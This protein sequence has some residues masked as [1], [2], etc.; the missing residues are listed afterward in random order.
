MSSRTI[1]GFGDWNAIERSYGMHP[2]GGEVLTKQDKKDSADINKIMARWLD[3]GVTVGM[4]PGDARYGDFSGTLD[5]HAAQNRIKDAE[6]EFMLQPAHIREACQHDLGVFLEKI[7]T[8][9]GQKELEALGL[10]EELVPPSAAVPPA[11]QAGSEAEAAPA[12][13][14]SAS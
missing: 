8:E 13:E 1:L 10:P 6:R 14:E 4:N 3:N 12:A 2:G 11:G 9:D 7:A 5:Y